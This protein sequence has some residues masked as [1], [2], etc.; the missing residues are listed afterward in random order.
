MNLNY[1]RLP[2]DMY[3]NFKPR[4][5]R[6]IGGYPTSNGITQWKTFVRCEGLECVTE[7][8]AAFLYEY[9]MRT[10]IDLRFCSEF[11]KNNTEYLFN[12]FS[13]NKI[14]LINMPFVDNY[15]DITGHYYMHMVDKGK[16]ILNRYLSI[17]ANGLHMAE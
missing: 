10:V 1:K 14:T 16:K 17:S 11:E 7:H 15:D 5:I 6:D 13:A 9:G 12:V 4:N 2:L 3:N 8:D